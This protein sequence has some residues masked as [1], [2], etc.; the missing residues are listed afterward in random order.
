MILSSAKLAFKY[1][2]KTRMPHSEFELFNNT[3]ML[4]AQSCK[5]HTRD[6]HNNPGGPEGRAVSGR[7][8]GH[9]R[10]AGGQLPPRAALR[11]R[12]PSVP[13]GRPSVGPRNLCHGQNSSQLKGSNSIIFTVCVVDHWW[14]PI[15][16][17]NLSYEWP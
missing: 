1:I 8:A 4:Y 9:V 17:S 7:A 2:L 10:G 3:Y 12:G 11:L 15:D 14:A 6:I 13:G 16:Y 5:L